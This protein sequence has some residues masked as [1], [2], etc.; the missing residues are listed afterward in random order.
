MVKYERDYIILKAQHELPTAVSKTR[1]LVIKPILPLSS[2]LDL[3]NIEAIELRSEDD[4]PLGTY[5]LQTT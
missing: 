2:S 5:R 1:I 4:R 3:D